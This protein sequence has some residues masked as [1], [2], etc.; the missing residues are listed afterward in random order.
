MILYSHQQFASHIQNRNFIHFAEKKGKP[1]LVVVPKKDEKAPDDRPDLTVEQ[2]QKTD[3]LSKVQP[4]GKALAE[5]FRK[6]EIEEKVFLE[7]HRLLLVDINEYRDNANKTSFENYVKA[8]TK[9]KLPKKGKG[10]LCLLEALKHANPDGSQSPQNRYAKE[11]LAELATEA[12]G[13]ISDREYQEILESLKAVS[14]QE[15]DED[16]E[17]KPEDEADVIDLTQRKARILID[18]GETHSRVEKSTKQTHQNWKLEKPPQELIDKFQPLDERTLEIVAAANTKGRIKEKLEATIQPN[19]QGDFRA[20]IRDIL[21]SDDKELGRIVKGRL[22]KLLENTKSAPEVLQRNMVSIIAQIN[23]EL[24]ELDDEM[25]EIEEKFEPLVAEFNE[26]AMQQIDRIRAIEFFSARAGLDMMTVQKLIGW[27]KGGTKIFGKKV[28]PKT[29]ISG[30]EQISMEITGFTFEPGNDSSDKEAP[31]HLIVNYIDEDGKK[32]SEP[33]IHFVR[34]MDTLEAYEPQTSMEDFNKRRKFELRYAPLQAGQTFAATVLVDLDEKG[35]A[36]YQRQH[37]QIDRIFQEI[38][39]DGKNDWRIQLKEP[40]E[41]VPLG[42]LDEGIHKKGYKARFHQTFN[43]GQFDKFIMQRG[44]KRVTAAEEDQKVVNQINKDRVEAHNNY[45]PVLDDS[46]RHKRRVQSMTVPLVEAKVGLT[47]PQKVGEKRHVKWY[48]PTYR[49]DTVA[50]LELVQDANGKRRYKL[51]YDADM[52]KRYSDADLHPD[53]KAL[54]NS[55]MK[56][57]GASWRETAIPGLNLKSQPSAL[58]GTW[59]EIDLDADLLQQATNKGMLTDAAVDPTNPQTDPTNSQYDPDE[60]AIAEQAAQL[61]AKRAGLQG[62]A[63]N[64]NEED[65]AERSLESRL[66]EEKEN[67]LFMGEGAAEVS[68]EA[69]PYSEVHK[70][71][72]MTTKERG[73]FKEMWA[74]TRFLSIGDLWEMGKAMYEYY[75]RRFQRRQKGRYA[76]VS[77][78]VPFFAPEMKRVGQ[79]AETEAMNQFKEAFDQYGVFEIL[80]RMRKTHNRDE[81]K[82]GFITL[83]SKGQ[84]RWDDID[85]WKNINRFVDPGVA[86]PIPGNGDPFTQISESDTRTGFDFLKGAI[87]SMWGDGGYND[88]Y[89]QNKSTY[90]SNAKSQYETGKELENM[91]GGPAKKLAELLRRHKSGEFV[92]PQEYEGLILFVIE[93][94]KAVM[95][96]KIY[97]ICEGIAAENKSGRTILSFDRLGHINSEMLVRFPLLQYMTDGMVRS[98]GKEHK[99]TVDDYKRWVKWFDNGDPQNPAKNRPTAAVDKFLWE[100]ALPSRSTRQRINKA[101]RDGE[102]IDH[103]DMFGYIPP[104]TEQV[105][106]DAC[107]STTGSKKFVTTEGYANVFPG[108]SEFLKTQGSKSNAKK[109]IQGVKS[110][111]RYESIMTGRWKKGDEGYARLDDDTLRKAPVVSGIPPIVFI[112]EGNDLVRRIVRAYNDT[113]L[114]EIMELMYQTTGDVKGNAD[115]R[116]KQNKIQYALEKFGRHFERVASADGGARLLAEVKATQFKGMPYT[117]WE[118]KQLRKQGKVVDPS[119]LARPDAMSA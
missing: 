104:A 46:Q 34:Q 118:V 119:L 68:D 19:Y 79:A 63:A 89:R 14:P 36:V 32:H 49:K 66:D 83:T 64:D 35:E 71:D 12:P 61:G 2:E 45:Q 95:Q 30:K 65:F 52:R 67:K 90:L 51:L 82:A 91:E 74:T 27:Y 110:Y 6:G 84:M 40:V 62:Q 41:T 72:G 15:K 106:N 53:V 70:V 50:T 29:G 59:R 60:A 102:R 115:E 99:P 9:G 3:A 38:T 33:F 56:P 57:F 105:V 11:K 26:Y 76:E 97:Y 75:E 31:G 85:I 73:F 16:E 88:W 18:Q 20:V 48:N 78:H 109:L 55:D 87:D 23:N 10:S 44:F 103:D 100:Y 39:T 58:G 101:L 108:F 81:L 4:H 80:D 107:K 42:W 24:T 7:M 86:I 114:N 37:F 5:K 92:D 21:Q 28:D 112:K 113:Q 69:K 25:E 17:E 47:I 98:D 8:L 116:T 94:G 22:K 77:K 1:T 96:D 117:P 13:A 43:L 111:V 93:Y 54:L